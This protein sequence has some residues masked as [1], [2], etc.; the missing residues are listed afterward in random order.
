MR[1]RD[2]SDDQRA[3]RRRADRERL[4]QA[5]RA[6]LSS[7]GWQR[8]V[9]VRSTNGLARYSFGNQLLIAMQRPDATYVAGFRAFLELNRCVRKGERAIR[10]LAP[11]SLRVRQ[12][13]RTGRERNNDSEDPRRTV[14]R[15]VSVFDVS[16]TDPLPGRDPVTLDPPSEPIE[17]DSHGHLLAPLD[18][19][20][21]ELGYTVRR[22]TLHGSADGWCDSAEHVIVVSDALSANA[23]VRVLV[24][25]IAHALGVGYSDHGRRRAEVLVDTVTFIVCGSMGLDTSGSSVPYVAGWGESGALDAIRTYAETIDRIARRIEDGLRVDEP[26]RES[27]Q[28]Q[29]A[30]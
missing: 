9:R 18:R 28:P 4:E 8:W 6:L 12:A 30:A 23:Q 27:K 15:A 25:E 21:G 5:A 17:G 11:M 16:Q 20:A 22:Q 26:V 2:L 13:E 19:L 14:F 24:H 29:L 10:I 3:E 1:K 7:D